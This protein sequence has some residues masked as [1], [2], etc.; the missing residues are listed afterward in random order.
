M[1]SRSPVLRASA[2]VDASPDEVRS[3]FLALEERPELYQSSTHGGFVFTEGSFGETGAQF[4]T[5]EW[6]AG[7]PV[8]L[9]FQLT[10]I[11]EKSFAFRLLAPPLPVWGAFE[12]ESA[13]DG[14]SRLS[15]LVGGEN[16]C[17]EW[18][19]RLPLICSAVQQQIRREV[20]HIKPS[21]EQLQPQSRVQRAPVEGTLHGTRTD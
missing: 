11:G 19:L 15:L 18:F 4:E 5:R 14:S 7:I 2:E 10:T 21:I 6:L 20:S 3:W 9:R 13:E 16:G 1:N 17:A 12:I 8:R